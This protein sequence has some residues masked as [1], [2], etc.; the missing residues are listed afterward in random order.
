MMVRLFVREEAVQV[1]VEPNTV[2]RGA[3]FPA[4]ERDLVGEAQNLFELFVSVQTL[5]KADLFG[6]KICAALDRQHPRD[7]F[8]VALLLNDEGITE[9][10]RKAFIVYLISHPRPMHELLN[11]RFRDFRKTYHNEFLGMV[12][13]PIVYDELLT[14]R[15]K[16]VETIRMVLT[17]SERRFLLSLKTGSPEW[18]LLGISHVPRLPAIQWKLLNIRNMSP[19]KRKEQL[20]Q[21]TEVLQV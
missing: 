13:I 2:I 7:L 12:R 8:D 18:S 3:V 20:R 14:T 15:K 19:D 17:D 4:V 10:T 21:L 1:K 9:K 11:P 6:G 5:S 16:L